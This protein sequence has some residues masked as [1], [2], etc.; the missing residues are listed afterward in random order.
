MQKSA[1]RM[2][3]AGTGS[4][5]GKTTVTCAILQALVNRGHRVASF[6]CGPDYIDPMFH[7]EIIGAQSANIDLFFAGEALARSLFLQHAAELNVIEGVMGYYDGTTLASDDAS[8]YRV[9]QALSAPAVLVVGGYGMALSVAAVVKGNTRSSVGQQNFR[10]N[11][12]PYPC[13]YLSSTERYH[14]AGMRRARLWVLARKCSVFA[15]KPPSG[16]CNSPR[17]GWPASKNGTAGHA[18]GKNHR[19]GRLTFAHA[20][21]G[22]ALRA[23]ALRAPAWQRAHRFGAGP[24]VLLLLPDNLEL[25]TALGATLVPFS[26]LCDRELPPCDGLLL[27]GGYPELTAQML[28][29]N[30]SMRESVRTAIADGLPTLAECGGFMYL[31]Q[32]IGSFPMVG[33]FPGE[34]CDTRGL[35]RFGYATLTAQAPCM[36]LDAG[37]SIR[38]HEFHYWDADCTGRCAHRRPAVRAAVDMRLLHRYP[39]RWLSAPL[40]A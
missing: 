28:S 20:G 38:G 1:A 39:L 14:R 24:G 15:R 3:I 16:P 19:S 8:S 13:E 5:C 7:T 6:K 25:L 4:G 35:S 29:E 22:T 40:S 11:F 33:V 9:A 26:P 18:G 23:G 37:E 10:R 27:G 12:Q 17:G 32:R 2:L 21:A 36:L 31:C 34:C 30:T